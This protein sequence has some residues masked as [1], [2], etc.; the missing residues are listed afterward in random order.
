[1][2]DAHD[3]VGDVSSTCHSLAAMAAT[4]RLYPELKNSSDRL[5]AALPM[6]P[7]SISVIDPVYL[8]DTIPNHEFQ[9][10]L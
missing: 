7:N 2:G 1:M 6:I 5:P 10:L 9:S 8:Q 3:V 4:A